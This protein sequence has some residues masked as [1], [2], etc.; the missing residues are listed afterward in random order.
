[1]ILEI[2]FFSIRPEDN[3]KFETAFTGAKKLLSASPGFI[4]HELHRCLEVQGRYALLVQ[5]E[6]LDAHLKGFRESPRF[7]QWRALLGP[8]FAAQP[9]VE[10]FV[11]LSRG[12]LGE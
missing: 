2:A 6:S 3:A 11:Q 1:M 10:H 5:W 9:T 8:Y 7:P 4:A 12:G